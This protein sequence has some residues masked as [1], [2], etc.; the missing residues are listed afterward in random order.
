M[1]LEEICLK[2]YRWIFG[3]K[4]QSCNCREIPIDKDKFFPRC[5]YAWVVTFIVNKS[6]D[7]FVWTDT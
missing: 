6:T 3:L 4:K 5:V 1:Y 7:Y 2:K